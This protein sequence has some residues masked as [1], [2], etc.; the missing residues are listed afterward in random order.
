M[1]FL[2]HLWRVAKFGRFTVDVTFFPPVTIKDFP[3]RKALAR[4]CQ[5]IIAGGI[6]QGLT[7]R[8]GP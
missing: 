7:G 4:Y 2:P 3:D 6:E 1:T 8:V 5:N